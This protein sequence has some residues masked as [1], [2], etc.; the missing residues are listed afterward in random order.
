MRQASTVFPRPTSSARS[1]R[2]GS[3]R[4]AFSATSSWWGKIRMRPPRNDASVS[5]SREE[6]R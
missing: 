1:Q 2:T 6:V 4:V 5:D 3:V